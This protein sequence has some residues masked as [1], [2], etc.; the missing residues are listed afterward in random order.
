MQT[1]VFRHHLEGRGEVTFNIQLHRYL[2]AITS[3]LAS[4]L[5]HIIPFSCA[6][7]FA[8]CPEGYSLC[9]SADIDSI[10]KTKSEKSLIPFFEFTSEF[11]GFG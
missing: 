2:Q 10:L 9:L 7:S 8:T 6:L 11:S 3:F 4:L 5:L 1:P